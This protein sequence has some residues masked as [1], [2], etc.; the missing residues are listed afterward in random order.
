M[1]EKVERNEMDDLIR[2]QA[3]EIEFT[4]MS[5]MSLIDQKV[6]NTKA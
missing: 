2:E 1:K 6:I 3:D 5:D 4:R